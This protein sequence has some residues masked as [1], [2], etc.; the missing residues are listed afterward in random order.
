MLAIGY[1][2]TMLYSYL[3]LFII[4]NL[5]FWQK[6][7]TKNYFILPTLI[8]LALIIFIVRMYEYDLFFVRKRDKYTHDG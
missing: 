3:K 1:E 6:Q 4:F 7:C 8:S 2:L 5:F